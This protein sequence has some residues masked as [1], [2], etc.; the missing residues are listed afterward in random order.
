M[1]S[2]L[3]PV[4]L[5]VPPVVGVAPPVGALGLPPSALPP[6]ERWTYFHRAW[7]AD[8]SRLAEE[9]LQLDYLLLS[10]T[11]AKANPEPDT[12]L[13]RRGLPY[14]VPLDPA[15]PDR[16][17]ATLSTRADRY[18]RIGWDR[19]KASDHC[20]LVIELTIPPT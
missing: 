7:S 20:P 1:F 12:M 15:A 19:P 5:D 4:A 14:R 6:A 3:P 16:S 13:I 8:A 17:I 10:P 2:E 11:L 18:P 9:H